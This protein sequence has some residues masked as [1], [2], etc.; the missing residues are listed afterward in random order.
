MFIVEMH[1]RQTRHEVATIAFYDHRT[2]RNINS[3]QRS[4]FI[5]ETVTH[6]N[7]LPFEDPLAVHGNDIYIDKRDHRRRFCL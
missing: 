6:N 3:R 5:D 4:Y 2:F 7:R 1:I